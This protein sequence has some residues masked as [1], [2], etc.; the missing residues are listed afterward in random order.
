MLA[1]RDA[2]RDVGTQLILATSL[3]HAGV[4][5]AFTVSLITNEFV[6]SVDIELGDLTFAAGDGLDPKDT[7]TGEQC[8]VG[9]DPAT[10]EQII[11]PP[12]PTGGWLWILTADQD[13]PV[14][15]YGFALSQMGAPGPLIATQLLDA[16]VTL[17][18]TGDQ[19]ALPAVKCTL[20]AFPLS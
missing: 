3:F 1:I 13:P 4:T 2:Q 11:T 17:T 14:T 19:L 7:D 8:T 18:N 9:I 15:I 6:P 16:P 20:P 12:E 10:A 5:G